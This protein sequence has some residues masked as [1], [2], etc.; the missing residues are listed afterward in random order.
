VHGDGFIHINDIDFM[1]PFDEPLPEYDPREESEVVSQI[2]KYVASLVQDGDTIQI[3]Y[4]NVPF[5]YCPVSA[6]KKPGRAFR[7]INR[8]DYSINE[9]R[10]Y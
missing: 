6:I 9:T 2:G 8:R 10:R 5:S 4:G 7:A 1:L 3:G